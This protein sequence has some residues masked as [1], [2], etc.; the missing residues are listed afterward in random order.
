MAGPKNLNRKEDKM[1]T[2]NRDIQAA[3]KARATVTLSK[4]DIVES[5][6]GITAVRLWSTA[7]AIIN[8]VAGTVSFYAGNYH[9]STTKDRINAV[10]DL[11]RV[12]GVVQRDF[13]WIMTDGKLFDDGITYKFGL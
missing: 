8:W 2:I 12:P 4:R 10:A 1:R 13:T 7:V 6:D 11:F 3:I 9:T 5:S